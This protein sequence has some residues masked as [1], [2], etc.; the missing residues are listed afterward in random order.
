MI[1]QCDV[2]V[3]TVKIFWGVH[4]LEQYIIYDRFV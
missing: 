2:D 3:M 1:S 4:L